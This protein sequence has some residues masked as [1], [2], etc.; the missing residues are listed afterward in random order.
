[1]QGGDKEFRENRRG[2]CGLSCLFTNLATPAPL[3][4]TNV[5]EL[6]VLCCMATQKSSCTKKKLITGSFDLDSVEW[7]KAH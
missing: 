5:G 6:F 3:L 2:S 1:M 7:M 4:L